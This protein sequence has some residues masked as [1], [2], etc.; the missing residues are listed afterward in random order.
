MY[1]GKYFAGGYLMRKRLDRVIAL[2]EGLFAPLNDRFGGLGVESD[3]VDFGAELDGALGRRASQHVYETW[4]ERREG[5]GGGVMRD[6]E[7]RGG[8]LHHAP[9]DDEAATQRCW[10]RID[11]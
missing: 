1:H 3:G 9:H 7:E 11:T 4:H 2:K 5:G 6:A 8:L 10:H